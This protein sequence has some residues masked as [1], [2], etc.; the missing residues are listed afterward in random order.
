MTD[1]IVR[2]RHVHQISVARLAW[3]SAIAGL[4]A[5]PGTATVYLLGLV[6]GAVD[7]KVVLPSLVGMGSLSLASVSVTTLA[8]VVAAGIMLGGLSLTT[9]R[10]VTTFRISTSV[11]ALLSLAMPATIPG[12]GP[13]MRLTMAAMHVVVWAICVG[14]LP[15]LVSQPR[16]GAA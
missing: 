5:W 8:A 7:E 11:L 15:T 16:R 14:L 9:R 10:P 3:A 13:A 2:Q 4:T 1:L 12:P 6:S